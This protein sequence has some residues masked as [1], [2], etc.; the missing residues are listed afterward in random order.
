M[1][2]PEE[3]FSDLINK[4]LAHRFHSFGIESI[5]NFDKDNIDKIIVQIGSIQTNALGL[6]VLLG[7][8]RL[9]KYLIEKFHADF[10]VLE[11]QLQYQNLSMTEFLILNFHHEVFMLALPMYLKKESEQEIF[12]LDDTIQFVSLCLPKLKK[13]V[14]PMRYAAEIGNI[15]F[16]KFVL[17]TF[18]NKTTPECFD[19][20]AVDEETGENCALIACAQ[21]NLELI[22]FLHKCGCDFRRKNNKN[23]TAINLVIANG[24]QEE[25]R[26]LF[27]ILTFLIEYVKLDVTENFEETLMLCSSKEISEY[28]EEKLKICG[29]NTTKRIVDSKYED[30][31]SLEKINQDSNDI[32]SMPS[33]ISSI[34]QCELSYEGNL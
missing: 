26:T 19:I 5:S 20:H 11:E 25:Y 15:T 14:H 10:S 2:K 28:I 12:Q 33:L 31:F 24:D 29:I 27:S 32:T 30:S 17:N 1:L 9:M 3:Y 22:I 6:S 8:V 34:E 7:D 18:K 13:E 4:T 23:E 16:F 21:G